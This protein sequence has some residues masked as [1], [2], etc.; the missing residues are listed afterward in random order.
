M[1]KYFLVNEK[2]FF[3]NSYFCIM[4]EQAEHIELLKLIATA[5]R[6]DVVSTEKALVKLGAK[7]VI[8]AGIRLEQLGIF[9]FDK[10]QEAIKITVEYVDPKK[11]KKP[12]KK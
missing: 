11:I 10:K 9:K 5:Y 12:K 3:N 1:I 7:D 6:S 4:D 8:D 2:Y